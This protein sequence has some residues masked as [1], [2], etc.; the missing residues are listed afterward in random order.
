MVKHYNPDLTKYYRLALFVLFFTIIQGV[1]IFQKP[2]INLGLHYSLYSVL[3]VQAISFFCAYFVV[4]K[5]NIVFYIIDI[6]VISYLF[7]H[8][9]QYSS[10]YL[11]SWALILFMSAI[12]L[13]FSQSIVLA[14]ISSICVSIVNL[15]STQWLGAQNLIN[16]LLFNLT[17]GLVLFIAY[18]FKSEVLGL[19]ESLSLSQI[20]LKSKTD[21][22][23][24]LIQKM[25]IGL[26]ATDSNQN[27]LY[28]N[29]ML[30]E[31]YK[32]DSFLV[33]SLIEAK[34]NFSNQPFFKFYNTNL[35]ESRFYELDEASYYDEELQNQIKLHLVRD[36]TDAVK[37]QD[38]LKQKEKM[39]AVGQLAA[40]IAHEIRNPLAGISGSIE[41]LSRENNNPDDQKLM[42][43]II[44][45]ID[46]LNNLIT[47]FLS[48]SRP[49]QAPDQKIDLS[50]II[51]EVV[52]NVKLSQSHLTGMTY[53]VHLMPVS[54][55][56]FSDKLKQVFM[57]IIVNAVQAM[58]DTEI[59]K[60]DIKMGIEN[61]KVVIEIKDTGCGMSEE[62]KKRLFEPFYTTKSK[63]TGLGMAIT[64]KIL[65]SHHAQIDIES[66]LGQGTQFKIYFNKA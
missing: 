19:K 17:F 65:E 16:L 42:K 46:R 4:K 11:I 31:N 10:L 23:D 38:D 60:I 25:P 53:N 62:T 47:E 30:T 12:D 56:G 66:Q 32:L 45:E 22:A 1:L 2:F 33:Q 50:I 26:L 15:K 58:K 48:Y 18:Q 63:G 6:L 49:E 28:S 55:Y 37:I 39:A 24:L 8:H 5:N 3:V 9:T 34:K 54:I 13:D 43:I 29:G 27:I 20:K 35:S 44:R 40:G 7:Y 57:N 14:F 41:L 52:Q 36:V 59:K 21:L 51:D 61:S 64:H